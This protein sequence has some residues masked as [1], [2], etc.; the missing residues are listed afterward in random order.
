M[1]P[2]H[3]FKETN[4]KPTAHPLNYVGPGVYEVPF[5]GT[6][7][8]ITFEDDGDTGYL[9][10]TTEGFDHIFDAL[11][12]YNNTDSNRLAVGDNAY[13]VWNPNL[14]KAGIYYKNEFHAV[15]D[16]MK[17]TACCRNNFPQPSQ[18]CCSNHKWYDKAAEGLG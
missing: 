18:W 15:I 1:S 6:G 7:F 3:F 11:H 17:Q 16:F 2:F 10:A 14:L 4:E 9:Y 13:I 8:G 5:T 12:L